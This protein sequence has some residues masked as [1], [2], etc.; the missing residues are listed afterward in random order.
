M[1]PITIIVFF[2]YST[3]IVGATISGYYMSKHIGKSV[4]DELHE[5]LKL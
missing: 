3:I 1:D 4:Y 2:S 5:I